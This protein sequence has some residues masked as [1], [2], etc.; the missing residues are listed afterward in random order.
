M[1]IH[2]D[3]MGHYTT[4]TGI[5]ADV[6]S[7]HVGVMGVHGADATGIS[8]NVKCAHAGVANDETGVLEIRADVKGTGGCGCKGHRRR[9]YGRPQG[10]VFTWRATLQVVD[11]DT[12]L[13]LAVPA[14]EVGGDIGRLQ[15][16]PRSVDTLY[17][18]RWARGGRRG[19]RGQGTPSWASE[20]GVP[21]LG[22]K[23]PGY[24]V[25]G[26]LRRRSTARNDLHTCD[27]LDLSYSAEEGLEGNDQMYRDPVE[28]HF[29]RG[30]QVRVG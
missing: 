2:A 12:G 20:T 13:H 24:P 9:R 17:R 3:V 23:R 11:S 27:S 29:E 6:K 4:V 10:I 30:Q 8:A 19:V 25:L 14:G 21:R 5:P 7:A 15:L 1:G 22:R 28:G 18:I 16:A 26:S